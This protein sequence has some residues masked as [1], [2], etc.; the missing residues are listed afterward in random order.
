MGLKQFCDLAMMLHTYK[1]DVFQE[2]LRHHLKELGME[3]AFRACGS[4]LVYQLGLPAEEFLYPLTDRDKHYGKRILDVVLYR[5]N[6]GYYNKKSGFQGWRH[7][8]EST[9]I[10][11]SH[12]VKFMP[13][14]P[15]YSFR[16]LG[17]ELVRKIRVKMW[18][19][20]G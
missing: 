9:G 3:K 5:G 17:H 19:K 15:S 18:N 20:N 13:L 8:I 7:N 16:W 6:M 2:T 12:F 11:L 1:S 14:A 4:I 10:K